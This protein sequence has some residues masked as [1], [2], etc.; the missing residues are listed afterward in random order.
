MERKNCWEIKRCGRESGGD[1][2]KVLGVCPASLPSE[3]DGINK[4]QK[5]GRFCW[6]I[7][8]TFCKGEVQGTY[9]KKL[10]NCLIC[11]FLKQVNEEEGRDFILTPR[12]AKDKSKRKA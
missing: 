3:Y 4:G 11:E 1:N 7:A 10:K 2:V 6:V 9:A 8:G 5:G 12:D